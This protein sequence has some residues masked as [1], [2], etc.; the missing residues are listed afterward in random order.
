M[1]ET[2]SPNPDRRYSFPPFPTVPEGVDLIPFEDFTEAGL[3]IQP[4]NYEGPEVDALNIPT[5]VIQKRHA[6]DCCKTNSRNAKHDSET[7]QGNNP[8]PSGA[9]A[10]GSRPPIQRTWYSEWQEL[11]MRRSGERYDLHENLADRIHHA[12]RV[13]NTGRPWPKADK[14]IREQ[15][16]QFQ[17]YMGIL[18]IMPIWRLKSEESQDEDEVEDD[19]A[20]DEK[21]FQGPN[22]SEAAEEPNQSAIRQ[23]GMTSARPSNV[24]KKK[25]RPRPPYEYYKGPAEVESK[26]DI[27]KLIQQ[28]K[29][30]K[31]DRLIDFLNDPKQCV[32]VYLSS[33]M[34]KQGFHYMER[35]LTLLP[36]LLRFYINFLIKEEIVNVE[37]ESEILSS[38]KSALDVLDIAELE[39][40]L[41]SQINKRIPWNDLF[42]GG[43]EELFE[44]KRQE[45]E[46]SLGWAGTN[47]HWNGISE[48]NGSTAAATIASTSVSEDLKSLEK[49]AE[50]VPSASE[51]LDL[52]ETPVETHSATTL[53]AAA[54]DAHD[55]DEG[56]SW[57]V[58]PLDAAGRNVWDTEIIDVQDSWNTVERNDPGNDPWGDG[59]GNIWELPP[60]PTLF[61]I[62]GPTAL[63]VTHTSGVVEWSMRRIRAIVHPTDAST[64]PLGIPSDGP[65]AEAV[66]AE[67]S[68]R[69]S[70]V[71]M[72]PWLNWES[73]DPDYEDTSSPQ[74]KGFS[75]G[76][77]VV[78]EKGQ[79]VLYENDSDIRSNAFAAFSQPPSRDKG[80]T[81]ILD[82]QVHAHDPLNHSITLLVEPES[83][84]LMRVG[85]GLGGTWIQ[86]ARQT[87][88]RSE[89]E[90]MD[91]GTKDENGESLKMSIDTKTSDAGTGKG[92][93]G[94]GGSGERF[95]YL[96]N[97]LIVLPSYYAL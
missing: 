11:S 80:E 75:R 40:P 67:L 42:S 18:N 24:S 89:Q 48:N 95:W 21:S 71:V 92:Y 88:L 6:G 33:Y 3:K 68:S 97:L 16:D 65:S 85:M 81:N 43:C 69:L 96:S 73:P 32:Q 26:E 29:E 82:G 83:A 78:Y 64:S 34:M 84:K 23:V 94:F 44:V 25:P 15:W 61:P 37:H 17:I 12:T 62:L 7:Q 76:R 13:F 72:E 49:D 27:D 47:Q 70:K 86:I 45:R 30:R 66:E 41:A 1:I 20:D 52:L 35:N 31:A 2:P 56:T 79:G 91:I 93:D 19:F 74:I 55:P 38:L 4:D 50:F 10:F 58:N 87:D 53:S 63:P 57:N 8:D 60:P 28:S 36:R 39:L 51:D 9:T 90:A 54:P 22:S 46:L 14:H 77:V 5:V 59:D